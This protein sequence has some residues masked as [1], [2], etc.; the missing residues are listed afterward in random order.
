V[1]GTASRTLRPRS[2]RA[3]GAPGSKQAQASTK[4]NDPDAVL[5]K[6]AAYGIAALFGFVLGNALFSVA[7]HRSVAGALLLLITVLG[8]LLLL[9]NQ[10]A[11]AKRGFRTDAVDRPQA[12]GLFSVLLFVGV[13]CNALVFD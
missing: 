11:M 13:L 7:R 1:S 10:E 5:S 2:Q 8:G 12:A 9:G 4:S 6:R 3:S